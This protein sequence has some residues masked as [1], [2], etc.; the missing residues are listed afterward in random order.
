M[1]GAVHGQGGQLAVWRVKG[2]SSQSQARATG[3]VCVG[4]VGGAVQ[5]QGRQRVGGPGRVTGDRGCGRG[6][7]VGAVRA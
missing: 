6:C 7:D 4:C 1:G 2:A 5:G 3:S